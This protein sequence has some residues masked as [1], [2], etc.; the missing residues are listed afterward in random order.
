MAVYQVLTT[1]AMVCMLAHLARGDGTTQLGTTQ[2]L[3][4]STVLY[5]DIDNIANQRIYFQGTGQ[6]RIYRPG[7]FAQ[8]GTILSG[9][10]YTPTMTGVYGALLTLDQT[11]GAV[12]DISVYDTSTSSID[13]GRVFSFSWNLASNSFS[14][15]DAVDVSIWSLF[16]TSLGAKLVENRFEGMAGFIYQIAASTTGIETATPKYKSVLQSGNSVTPNIRLYLSKPEHVTLSSSVPNIV[17]EGVEF[18]TLGCFDFISDCNTVVADKVHPRFKFNT[19]AAGGRYTL[20]CDTNSDGALDLVR[21]TDTSLRG[22]TVAGDNIVEW[23]GRDDNN[24]LVTA[25]FYTCKMFVYLDEIHFPLVDM[26]TVYPGLRMFDHSSGTPRPQIMYWNDDGVNAPI[27]MP[28]G[29]FGATYSGCCG[30]DSGVSTDPISPNV[31]A[32][33]WG[34]FVS[35]SKGD[36]AILNTF[37]LVEVTVSEAINISVAQPSQC[38]TATVNLI[39]YVLTEL[40]SG[41]TVVEVKLAVSSYLAGD[42][43]LAYTTADGTATA[44]SGDYVATSGSI[45]ISS[46]D[47]CNSLSV[48]INGDDIVE[49]DEWFFLDVT[50]TAGPTVIIADGRANVTILND[51]TP[52]TIS[53]TN[54]ATSVTEPSSGSAN[55][56]LTFT[57]SA[58]STAPVTVYLAT[59][60]PGGSLV[61]SGTDFTP[62]PAS[63]VIPAGVTTFTYDIPVAADRFW[64][65]GEQF[66]VSIAGTSVEGAV[67]GQTSTTFTI[68]DSG[69]APVVTASVV[70]GNVA[71]STGDG[72]ASL[73]STLPGD[74][75][76]GESNEVVYQ[77]TLS[78]PS[79]YAA[80]LTLNVDGPATTATLPGDADLVGTI[81]RTGGPFTIAAG[82]TSFNVSLV[83]A[84][85]GDAEA[86]E[87][88]D[89]DAVVN[90]NGA[91]NPTTTATILTNIPNDDVAVVQMAAPTAATTEPGSGTVNVPI[92]VNLLA[93]S[94]SPV[95]INIQTSV[96]S[97]SL[98]TGGAD[99]T[100]ESTTV[101][102]PPGQMSVVYNAVVAAD[103]WYDGG[104]TF[105]VKITGADNGFAVGA[106]DTTVVTIAD[107]GPAPVLTAT[108]VGGT[109]TAVS[110]DGT[111][112]IDVTGPE[113]AASTTNELVVE[114]ALS[115]PSEY[116]AGLT[117]QVD[118]VTSTADVPSDATIVDTVARTGSP[119]TIPALA[120]TH[121][122]SV[123]VSGDGVLEPTEVLD[124]GLIANYGGAELAAD[125]VSVTATIT[126]DDAAVVTMAAGTAAATEPGSGTV[127]VPITQALR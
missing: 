32:R 48:T 59:T 66:T 43:T 102:V 71:S 14:Q 107:S 98:A 80:G 58:P 67:G 35:G 118:G 101:V 60:A 72:T 47:F 9:Q 54:S 5:L 119:M 97:G 29:Q 23:D 65:D 82:E 108:V 122:V 125:V 30:I 117:V 70:S 15:S 57:L 68:N 127:N 85:D 84:G 93:T 109:T 1:M 39:D 22:T 51:D 81:D 76:V 92:T 100:A 75:R 95:T 63:I 69:P 73:S 53:M 62:P 44:G 8:V 121:Q 36:T 34:N 21:Q 105:D 10:L 37:S 103:T 114:L 20:V 17:F 18:V 74:G 113:G 49:Y 27:A 6:L 104:E 111:D 41:T 61:T 112:V 55:A 99:F 88:V 94:P 12:W 64:D 26:E 126:N 28:N 78:R 87:V 106:A 24:A 79:E 90:L 7:D 52:V 33:S 89:F 91:S 25:G 50:Q 124:L 115:R 4:A 46:G 40:D 3:Q 11:Y 56:G 77:L 45:V 16:S 116:A 123:V 86:D 2:A 13:A 110:G 31:N 42:I 19:D 96:S 120:T 83:V 38:E